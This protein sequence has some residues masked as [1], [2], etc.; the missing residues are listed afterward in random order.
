MAD[1]QQEQDRNEPATPYKLREAKKRGQVAKSLE[2]NSLV[3]LF[4]GFVLISFVGM[5][6]GEKLLNL[7]RNIFLNAHQ[8]DGS[9]KSAYS[10]YGY[11]LT[12]VWQVLLPTA[13]ILVLSGILANVG[14]T[15]FLLSGFPLKPDIKRLNPVQGFKRVFSKK[16]LIEALKSVI[17]ILFFGSIAYFTIRALMPE[18][19]ALMNT[20]IAVYP[21]SIASFMQSLYGRL[22]VA[23]LIVALID[24]VYTRWDFTKR[25]RMSKREIKEEVKRREG[26][27]LIK[28]KLREY[29]K[30]AV[31]RAASLKKLPDADILI[32]NPTHLS[33]AIAY[34][35]VKMSAPIVT[36]KGAGDMALK[37]RKVA[38]KHR[39]AVVENKKIARRLFKEANLDESIPTALFPDIA[40]MLAWVYMQRDINNQGVATSS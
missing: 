5:S 13:F 19:F 16:M 21:I 40:K 37:M 23:V 34:D 39:V 32:T 7:F 29:Q 28:A 24:L 27:P 18:L 1:N 38:K 3:I 22:L 12:S 9:A 20:Q 15:G 8:F 11:T 33:I 6:L 25:M 4:T 36:A 35:R 17:K 26:D 14:Q 30:E 31:K 10:M 2:I